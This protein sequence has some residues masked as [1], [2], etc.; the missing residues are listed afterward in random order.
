[1]SDQNNIP[2]LEQDFLTDACD[3][4]ARIAT[5]MMVNEAEQA[6]ATYYIHEMGTT[7]ENALLPHM[8]V[9]IAHN[10]RFNKT[11]MEY[12]VDR[13]LNY[14]LLNTGKY[15]WFEECFCRKLELEF[16]DYMEFHERILIVRPNRA[17]N[18]YSCS[19]RITMGTVGR[20]KSIVTGRHEFLNDD[21]E[22]EHDFS[23]MKAE[24]ENYDGYYTSL[25]EHAS[26]LSTINAKLDDETYTVEQAYQDYKHYYNDRFQH[27]YSEINPYSGVKDIKYYKPLYDFYEASF[28]IDFD[29]LVDTFKKEEDEDDD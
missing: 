2:E 16:T 12:T 18:H 29:G 28:Y 23:K 4:I 17:R 5:T 1:M 25:E 11:Y 3:Y 24:A 14:V 20:W 22:T 6:N 21:I 9:H 26:H 10:T 15:K 27:E 13:Q 19:D 7:P 8:M